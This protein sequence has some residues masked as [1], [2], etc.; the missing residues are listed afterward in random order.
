MSAKS[1]AYEWQR[2]ATAMEVTGEVM[3]AAL[4][5][6][7]KCN[8]DNGSILGGGH[9]EDY[10]ILMELLEKGRVKEY[11]IMHISYSYSFDSPR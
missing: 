10:F 9:E 4:R 1:T 6:L 5:G 7:I 8:G 11:L 2:K 3:I